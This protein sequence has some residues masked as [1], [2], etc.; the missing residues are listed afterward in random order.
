MNKSF[1]SILKEVCLK[2]NNRLCIGLDIDCNNLSISNDKITDY[3][4]SFAKEIIDATIE[5]CP[6]YKPNL[7]FYERFGSK[8]V[9][10]LEKIV[11]HI[12][13]RAI[14]IADGKRGD[15]GNTTEKYAIATFEKMGFDSITVSPYMGR[16]SIIPFIKNKNKGAFVLCL[17]SNESA[18]DFQFHK[19]GEYTLW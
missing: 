16:D 13:G 9:K 11:E 2:K 3:I 1:N 15:I 12:N 7:A 19:E 5:Y 14:T 18:L 17:T 10:A 8:G 6:L 4:E